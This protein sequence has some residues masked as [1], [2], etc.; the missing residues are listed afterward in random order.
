MQRGEYKGECSIEE[1]SGV[2]TTTKATSKFKPCSSENAQKASE[3]KTAP[4]QAPAASTPDSPGPIPAGFV[5]P[6]TQAA[7]LS[8]ALA[9]AVS[10][11]R[12]DDRARD[13]VFNFYPILVRVL[14]TMA[15]APCH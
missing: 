14:G 4:D 7:T 3:A 1:G 6:S 10:D 12:L 11:G 15:L 5:P 9:G 8:E 2:E 13:L